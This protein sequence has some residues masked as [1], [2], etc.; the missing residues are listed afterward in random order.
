MRTVLLVLLAVA[1]A[2]PTGRVLVLEHARLVDGTGR[3]PIE[4]ARI[5][6][7]GERISAVGAAASVPVPAGAER[8][9]LSGRT[10]LPG[11]VDMH[12]HIENSAAGPETGAAATRQRRDGLP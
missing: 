1:A 2:Q 12:F 9:D 5:V 7:D 11:L 8:V 4:D 6:I 10:V 3:P